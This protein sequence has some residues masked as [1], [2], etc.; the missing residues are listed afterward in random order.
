M[1]TESDAD[2]LMHRGK[3]RTKKS[4]FCWNPNY[5]DAA[6][7]F[8]KAAKIYAGLCCVPKAMNA[9]QQASQTYQ[10][11]RNASSAGSC[12]ENLGAFLVE[13][14]NEGNQISEYYSKG[15]ACFEDAAKLYEEDTK[16][17]KQADVL[18]K[19]ARAMKNRAE[20]TNKCR[21]TGGDI[22]PPTSGSPNNTDEYKRLVQNAMRALE[23][24]WEQENTVP[25]K[26]LDLYQ[27]F[28]L[29]AIRQGDILTAVE[30][31]KR[32][33]GFVPN[34]P[35]NG[36]YDESKSVIY[37]LKCPN[38]AAKVGL[39]VVVLC[40]SCNGDD[41]WARQEFNRMSTLSGFQGTSEQQAAAAL[42]AAYE[43][44]DPDQLSE[45]IK[46]YTIFNFLLADVSR[47]VKK[48]KI[49]SGFVEASVPKSS[50]KVDASPPCVGNVEE[51]LDPEDLR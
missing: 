16:Y 5:E 32:M 1:S 10:H 35:S 40:L 29:Q 13:T 7:D 44:R 20:L 11:A 2:A 30:A 31:Q 28:I 43:E 9:W 37:R 39:E 26:L 6:S 33:L 48:L 42:L 51:E 46:S 14:A 38:R 23:M 22:C 25:Y 8:C 45:V 47:M 17:Q 36:A 50:N 27:E 15:I 41:V 49:G 18:L 3:K 19:A 34:P 24:S 4:L 21:Q 12:L